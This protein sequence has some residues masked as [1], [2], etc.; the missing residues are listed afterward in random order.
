[1]AKERII[2]QMVQY[3]KV[4]GTKDNIQNMVNYHILMAQSIKVT[5]LKVRNLDMVN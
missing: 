5:G 4:I 1:M 3:I 2:I